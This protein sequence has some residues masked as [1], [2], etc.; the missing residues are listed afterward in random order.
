[1][2]GDKVIALL[3]NINRMSGLRVG[4][5]NSSADTGRSWGPFPAPASVTSV[6]QLLKV[7]TRLYIEADSGQFFSSSDV[8]GHWDSLGIPAGMALGNV[9]MASAE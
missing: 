7:G 8:G 3:F 2:N 1:V 4:S 6:N 5:P 9:V